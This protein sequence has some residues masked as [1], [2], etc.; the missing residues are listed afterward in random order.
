MSTQATLTTEMI[1]AGEARYTED[2][3]RREAEIKAAG[4]ST[5]DGEVRT[6]RGD[7]IRLTQ[8]PAK[9]WCLHGEDAQAADRLYERW[10][11]LRSEAADVEAALMDK[12]A[13]LAA[14]E[15]DA[16]EKRAAAMVDAA[17]QG[18]DPDNKPLEKLDKQVSRMR[19]DVAALEAR[20]AILPKAISSCAAQWALMASEVLLERLHGSTP[21]AD[22]LAARIEN[23]IPQLINEWRAF[24]KA[25]EKDVL[26]LA[27]IAEVTGGSIRTAPARLLVGDSL[28]DHLLRAVQKTDCSVFLRAA[29]SAHLTGGVTRSGS[30]NARY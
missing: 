1:A 21:H 24:T 30:Y 14:L 28:A 19:T 12:R 18:H 20:A 17:I 15:A 23:L 6:E 8:P 26:A 2:A 7:K 4:S 16:D 9:C 3:Q 5:L 10:R 22:E 29:R 13:A 27:H 25:Q 11:A